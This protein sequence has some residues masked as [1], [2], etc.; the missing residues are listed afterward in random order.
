[1]HPYSSMGTATAW[2]KSHSIFLD[3]SDF[4]MMDNLSI[5]FYTFARS[6]QTSLSVDEMLLPNIRKAIL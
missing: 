6:T 5:T 3:R 1:M 4:D 2:K